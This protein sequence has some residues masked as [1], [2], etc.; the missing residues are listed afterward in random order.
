MFVLKE[1][2]G[3]PE[4]EMSELHRRSLNLKDQL[5]YQDWENLEAGANLAFRALSHKGHASKAAIFR[6]L[7]QDVDGILAALR[8]EGNV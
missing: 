2:P 8:A 3:D 6:K 5:T 1:T 7:T 4:S